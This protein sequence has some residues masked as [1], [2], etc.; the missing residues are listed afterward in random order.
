MARL[1]YSTSIYVYSLLIRL[2][3]LFY[4]KAKSFIRGRKNWENK[5][6]SIAGLSD[7]WLW[8]HCSSLGEFEQGRPVIEKIRREHPEMSI[9]LTFFSPSGYKVRKDYKHA[10][11]VMYMP[12]DTKRNARRFIEILQPRASLFIKYEF[13]Y[14]H[15]KALH[16]S[17]IPVFLI[18]AV[19]RPSQVFFKWYGGFFRRMLRFYD[20]IFVQDKQSE[21]LLNG[22]HTETSISGDT[23]FDRVWE[24]THE[25]YK[26]DIPE[27]FSQEGKL[28]LVAGS[29]WIPDETILEKA[30]HAFPD[31]KLILAPHETDTN[32]IEK[33]E[34]IFASHQ[35][36]MFS[37]AD[38][39]SIKHCRV[40]IID[41][42]GF[43]SKIYRYGD[44]AY[45]GG[46]FG[47]GIH[48]TLEAACYGIPVIFG[49]NFQRFNEA[50]ELMQQEAAF[51]IDS[52]SELIRRINKLVDDNY[53]Q[54]AGEKALNY[55]KNK[56]GASQK[57]LEAL[58][59]SDV[60]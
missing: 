45:I 10:D 59:K 28:I 20:T 23:R 12:L 21:S 18:S 19:F 4:P 33:V 22:I 35:T 31:M 14:H 54:T 56:R 55:V 44:F 30:L 26:N 49:P 37:Q 3:A 60:F 13:W 41:S 50:K 15:L 40:L 29:T 36:C 11:A 2:A 16:R 48:N 38:L 25:A 9:L 58:Q 7:R 42:M 1:I 6:Q 47:K 32:R 46:G 5:L 51:S 39:K 53:R 27:A 34:G 43:L 57:I 24:I 17:G 8:V 52:E